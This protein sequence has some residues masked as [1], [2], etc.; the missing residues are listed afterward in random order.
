MARL[1]FI[2]FYLYLAGA[3]IDWIVFFIL[4]GTEGITIEVKY[5]YL[6]IENA[7]VF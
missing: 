4:P 2:F 3:R 5:K 6:A 7:Q 1:I